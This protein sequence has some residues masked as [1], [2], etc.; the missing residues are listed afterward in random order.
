MSLAQ[1]AS[2]GVAVKKPTLASLSVAELRGKVKVTV[3]FS[4]DES[5]ATIKVNLGV[6]PVPTLNGATKFENV[7]AAEVE[8]GVAE[9]TA[10]INAGQFDNEIKAVQAKLVESSAKAAVSREAKKAAK[11]VSPNTATTE[12]VVAGL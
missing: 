3:K 9:L 7:P 6:L 1:Y 5:T 4:E 11:A 12:E 10:A 2:S 8:S